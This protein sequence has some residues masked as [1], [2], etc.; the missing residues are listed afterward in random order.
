M[1]ERGTKICVPFQIP[2]LRV[3]ITGNF[4]A[5]LKTFLGASSA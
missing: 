2:L 3:K 1:L 5:E 4:S